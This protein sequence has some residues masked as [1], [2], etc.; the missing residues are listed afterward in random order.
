MRIRVV[1]DPREDVREPGVGIDVVEF[2]GDDQGVDGG[3]PFAATIG[4]GE[5]PGAATQGNTAQGAFGGVIA[6]ADPAIVQEVRKTIDAGQDIVHRP[7]GFGL[8]RHAFAALAH[9][10]QQIRHHRRDMPLP[11][12]ALVFGLRAI[13]RAFGVENRID[14][15]HG[16]D[17]QRGFAP[18]RELEQTALACAQQPADTTGAGSRP[19]FDRLL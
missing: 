5:H 13:D 12:G 15:A 4:P 9:P 17:G 6:E 2:G 7:G 14:P 16:L 19:G 3:R 1:V 18:L 8:G 11:R 10:V